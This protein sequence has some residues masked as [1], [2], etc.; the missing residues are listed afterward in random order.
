M[1]GAMDPDIL[2]GDL[3]GMGGMGG[4]NMMGMMP[5]GGMDRAGHP[6][7]HKQKGKPGRGRHMM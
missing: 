6:M 5:M 3:M 2:G 1:S 4:M 7:R